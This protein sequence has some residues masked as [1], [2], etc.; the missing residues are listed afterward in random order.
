MALPVNKSAKYCPVAC[1]GWQ[2]LPLFLLYVKHRMF[3]YYIRQCM[4]TSGHHHIYYLGLN[5]LIS[6]KRQ[7][8][9]SWGQRKHFSA[10]VFNTPQLTNV[11]VLSMIFAST[12]IGLGYL[13]SNPLLDRPL[14]SFNLQ[15]EDAFVAWPVIL[16]SMFKI[17]CT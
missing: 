10:A 12:H 3:L 4:P 5:G 1:H 13:K 2:T 15:S 8:K 16:K 17:N 14:Y 6:R 9:N 7:N 11:D